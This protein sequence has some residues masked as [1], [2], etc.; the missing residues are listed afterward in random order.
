MY[1]KGKYCKFERDGYWLKSGKISIWF[2]P[3]FV[4]D[5]IVYVLHVL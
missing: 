2:W 4:N 5:T 1:L 3:F